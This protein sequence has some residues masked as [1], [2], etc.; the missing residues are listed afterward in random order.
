MDVSTVALNMTFLMT[1]GIGFLIF[2]AH[3]LIFTTMLMMAGA[4]HLTALTFTALWNRLRMAGVPNYQ[5]TDPGLL[6][7][8]KRGWPRLFLS[9]GYDARE[10]RPRREH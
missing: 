6:V 9:L 8:G 3:V 7:I 10:Q 2:L 1:L 4:A 5:T